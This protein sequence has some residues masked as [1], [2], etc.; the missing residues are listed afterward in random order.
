MKILRLL[1]MFTF[2]AWSATIS[3]SQCN[4]T[5]EMNDSYGDGWNGNTMDVLVGG[6]VVL[7]DVTLA[8]GAQS[9]MTFAVNTGDDVTTIWNGGGSY[10]YET[11]YRILDITGSQVGPLG[12]ENDITTGNITANCPSCIAPVNLAASS[13]TP[14]TATGTWD[15]DPTA[16][17]GY[18]WEVVPSGDGQGNNV[19]ASGTVG[20]GV[21]SASISSL[22]AQ[23]TYDLY[24]QSDCGSGTE[25]SSAYTFMTPCLAV[26]TF[27]FNE[28][29]ESITTGQPACWG[30]AGTS[31][32]TYHFYSNASG[33]TGRGM[34]FDSYYNG[35][36]NTSELTTPTLD[37]SG[38]STARLKFQFK[39][40]TGGNFEVLI[41]TNGG[42]TYTSLETGLT[43]QT[44]WLEKT[45]DIT[46]NIGSNVMIQFKGT[47]NYGGGDANIYLD[48]VT[49]EEIPSCTEP[50]TLTTASITINSADL[51]WTE[52]GTAT[53]WEVEY[54]ANGF[55]QGTGTKVVTGSNPY[56]LTGLTPETNYDFYVRAICA[57]GDTSPVVGPASFTTLISCPAVTGLAL[58]TLTTTT[59]DFT[60][61]AGGAETSW[62]VEYGTPGFTMGTGT[63]STVSS[64][65]VNLT[66]LMANTQYQIAIRA[67]CGV[68]DTSSVVGGT[69]T[70]YPTAPATAQGVT[71]TT[72]NGASTILFTEDFE[73]TPTGWTGSINGGNGTWEIPDGATSSNTGADDGYNGGNFMN[74]E[75]SN[76]STNQGSIVSPAIDLSSASDDAELSFWMHAY[77]ASMGTLEVGV[78]TAAAGPFTTEFTWTG[79][80]QRS[81]GADWIN[82][83]VDLSAYVGQTIYIQFTQIDDNNGAGDGYNG[84]MCIDAMMVTACVVAATPPN[85]DAA[86]TSPADA[87]TGIAVNSD[88]SWSTATGFPSGYKLQIG[89]TMGGS[90]FLTQ[91]DV[92]NV[93]TY[94]TA[95]DFDFNTTYYVNITPYNASGDAT[96]CTEYSF[97][98]GSGCVT[99]TTPAD[100]A[101][102][103]STAS[104]ASWSAVTGVAGYKVSIGTTA[105]GTD[106]V[107]AADN[108]TATTYDMSGVSLAYNTTYYLTIVAYN[109]VG[110]ATGCTSTSF[111]TSANP[112][113][114]GGP[115]GTDPNQMTSGGYYFANSLAGAGSSMTQPTYSWIDPVA[116]GHTEITSW[117]DDGAGGGDDSY[118]TIPDI[119]FDFPFWG[120]NYRTADAHINSNGAIGFAATATGDHDNTGVSASF[121]NTGEIENVIAGCWMDLDD[122]TNGKVY[123][124]GDAT[125]FVITWWHYHDY[126]DDNEYITFQ[127]ILYSDGKIIIQYNDTES[128]TVAGGAST[129]ILGDALVGIE[130][131]AGDKGVEYRNNGSGGPMFGSPMAL[132]F[133]TSESA[134]PVE[135]TSFTAV[136]E[137]NTNVLAWETASEENNAYF[138]VER[139]ANG[140]DFETIGNIEGN[141]TTV[142]VSNYD[143]ID[144]TPL[145]VSY[146]RLRQVDFDGEFAYSDVKVVKRDNAVNSS[147]VFYPVPVTDRLTIDF[148]G[149]AT[150]DLNITVTDALGR[151]L[152]TKTVQSIVGENQFTI[153]FDALPIGTY[154]IKLQSNNANVIRT[155]VKK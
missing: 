86:M 99:A 18:N 40:P 138:D 121:P 130:N 127:I 91:T 87:A 35:S 90:E 155:I 108:G 153:D 32:T 102:S 117:T 77:G 78:S 123:Y 64:A 23:T 79:Q 107:N 62:A 17:N 26:T 44:T 22:T 144:E 28:D 94:N 147:A 8:N 9:T 16:T 113:Y 81:G 7:D 58:N 54:G 82:V 124:G 137:G 67:I 122:R 73:T 59:A 132:A 145:T 131:A 5:L 70:T 150:E 10:G 89:T 24:V 115:D 109:N 112:N 52:A 118:F 96:T 45:Y 39:N 84:D 37:L 61:T 141:G 114:G 88:I 36:G 106:I 149:T 119:G 34:K 69:F 53:S 65:A 15:L 51:G 135:M 38:L 48:D 41:S 42:S 110:D 60:W 66:G 11:S 143:F 75:A 31:S 152:I 3:W 128:L 14:T 25:W 116:A 2:I 47:S 139:S 57:P 46:A 1:L 71:C 140:I 80:Y 98:T 104:S 142:E 20:V 134:L 148:V 43:G 111:T 30:I 136:A 105:G 50:N 154:F 55:T 4:Y 100:A 68:G 56:S 125:Q 95:N 6:V 92:G 151:Q 76:T 49:V 74:Y 21:N 12:D 97:T 83:G 27:P 93:L 129:T 101:T 133:N 13:I 126:G 63:K 85:C 33:F 146:Y 72:P 19:V 29:F 120:T 103:V